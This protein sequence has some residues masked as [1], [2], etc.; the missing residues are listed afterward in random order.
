MCSQDHK[1]VQGL[2][3]SFTYTGSQQALEMVIAF[4]DDFLIPLVQQIYSEG[5]EARMQYVLTEEFGGL[6]ES[7]YRLYG[8]TQNENHKWYA[9]YPSFQ[10]KA[11]A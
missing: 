11:L 10:F 6:Q 8:T 9:A 2:L 7:L 1:T 4:V 5:G 3:D